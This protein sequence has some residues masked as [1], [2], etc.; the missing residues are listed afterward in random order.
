MKIRILVSSVQY[1]SDGSAKWSTAAVDVDIRVSVCVCVWGNPW[2]LWVR[3]GRRLGSGGRAGG[4][5]RMGYRRIESMYSVG[6][7]SRPEVKSGS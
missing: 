6:M 4:R 7:A 1:R 2:A 3:A 5:V